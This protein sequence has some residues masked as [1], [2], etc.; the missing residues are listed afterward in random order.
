MGALGT[1]LREGFVVEFTGGFGVEPEVEL[2][3]PA[4]FEAGF[5]KG[6]VAELCAGV[7]FGEV[8]GVGG[9]FVGDNAVFHIL[10]VRQ[11]EVFLGRDIAEHRAAIPTDHGGSDAARDVVVAGGDVGGERAERV[12]WRFVAPLELLRHVFLDHVHGDMAGAFVH[13]LDA[14][15]P[16]AF[17]EVT[18]DFEFAE[19]RFVVG[20]GDRAGAESVADREAHI[21]SRHDVA[22]VVPVR[23]EKVLLVVGEAPFRHDAAAAGDNAGHARGGEGDE[24]Q[25]DS[26][27]DGEIIDAL[28]GLLD[29][30][31]GENLPGQFLG[32]ASD[33]FEGLVNGD[34]ADGDGRVAED[35]F[36]RG[37]DVFSGGEVHHGVGAPF[38]GPAHFLNFLLDAGGNGGVADVGVDFDE[39][40]AADDHRLEFGVV[41]I[42]RNDR[43][44]G[45]DFLADEFRRDLGGDALGE[46]SEDAR[47]V[48][49]VADLRGAGVLFIKI[50]AE[51]VAAEFGDLGAAH[52][53]ADGDEFHLR[54]NDSL[55]GIPE[56]GDGV[57]G[58]R[59]ERLAAEAGKFEEAVA[60]GL[61]GVFGVVAG[62]VAVVLWLD[63]A[64]VV[65][66]HIG[67][68][69][70][71]LGAESG[72]ALGDIAIEILV[73]P[74]PRG[75]IDADG[76]VFFQRAVEAFGWGERN[77]AHRHADSFVVAPLDIDAGGVWERVGAAGFEGF[78]GC[79]H[80]F[81]W[82]RWNDGGPNPRSD[83]AP[84][85]GSNRIRFKGSPGAVGRSGLSANQG[86][87]A[88]RGSFV[89][90]DARSMWKM[91]EAA[92]DGKVFAGAEGWLAWVKISLPR[93]AHPRTKSARRHGADAPIFFT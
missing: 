32:L 11:A 56:L 22:N 34:G 26:G 57:A 92:E 3:L 52:V 7:A 74:G 64:A 6:V 63:L 77:L 47:R 20:V 67:A 50:I 54:G 10:L 43:A 83:A 29:E 51:D 91:R 31:V 24:A 36:A 71:P 87:P 93:Q 70:D 41:D 12:E 2:V 15:R 59:A 75:V 4:E 40:V 8:G 25:E 53:F 38:G 65:F 66:A 42:C 17:G 81:V 37:V 61:A 60:L 35:P 33:F 5:R 78:G 14:F 84:S 73:A 13:D 44:A 79:D 86:S 58:G 19:L 23:V 88:G 72:E 46:T 16:G 45:G 68:G 48:R 55:A 69:F 18:L 1:F 62:K 21:V 39:E 90:R 89:S 76:L 80:G 9:D 28:L 27:V 30:R 85:A 49:A 82:V